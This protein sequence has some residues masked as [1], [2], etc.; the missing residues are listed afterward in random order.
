MLNKIQF[1]YASNYAIIYS[2]G[3]GEARAWHNVKPKITKLHFN[4][5]SS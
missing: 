4:V 3:T 1:D 2:E 5:V